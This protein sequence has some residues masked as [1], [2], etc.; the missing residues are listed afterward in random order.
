[1][2][3]ALRTGILASISSAAGTSMNRRQ[4]VI[5]LMEQ[6]PLGAEARRGNPPVSQR[7]SNLDQSRPKNYI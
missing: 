3:Y 5:F 2:R 1:M 7:F 6:L 4:L